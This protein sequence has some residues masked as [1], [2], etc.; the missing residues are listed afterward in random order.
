MEI[1]VAMAMGFVMFSSVVKIADKHT[2]V[3]SWP[4]KVFMGKPTNSTFPPMLPWLLGLFREKKAGASFQDSWSVKERFSPHH[5]GVLLD[6]H[7]YR[8]S[9]QKSFNHTV[10][11]APSG[12][13]KTTRYVIPNMCS[14]PHASLVITDIKGELYRKTSGYLQQQGYTLQVLNLEDV[15]HSHG[16]NPLADLQNYSDI[17]SI[18]HVLIRSANVEAYDKDPVWYKGAEIMLKVIISALKGM[19]DPRMLHL[20]NVLYTLQNM[21]RTQAFEAFLDR[22]A[23]DTAWNQYSQLISSNAKM[24]QSYYAIATGALD[25]LNDPA[26][27]QIFAT[28]ELHFG[29]LRR[30]KTALFLIIPPRKMKEYSVILNLVF[31]Q[32]FTSLMERLPRPNDRSVYILADEFGHTAIPNFAPISTTIRQYRVHLSIVL[33]SIAQLKEHYGQ[34]AA[35][36]ILEGGMG[37]KLF[38]GGLDTE[39]AGWASNMAGKERIETPSRQGGSPTYREQNLLNADR[40][41]TLG[42]H[43]A[44]MICSNQEPVLFKDTQYSFQHPLF[45]R[46]TALPPAPLPTQTGKSVQY[47]QF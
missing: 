42:D 27:A 24:V 15:A 5:E 1:L 25:F 36:T 12:S 10:L 3:F 43:E 45:K 40:I 41:R 46:A 17:A 2:K 4:M 29:Q 6:G 19:N 32:L 20:P 31:T 14:L 18:A 35:K 44:L 38:Y 22:Y 23:D 13:G 33:Q 30:Q 37:T 9:E 39:T 7:K 21:G 8:L 26:L 47:V 11:M 28:H 16:C 34:N